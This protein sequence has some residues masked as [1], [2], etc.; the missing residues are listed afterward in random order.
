[1]SIKN[2]IFDLGG[3]LV[4]FNPKRR[5]NELFEEQYHN[6]INEN[7]YLSDEWKLMDSGD[8]TTE[9]AEEIMCS[10]LP[11]ELH[12]RVHEILFDHE[13]QMPPI[14]N[15]NLL[16]E[17]LFNSG[18]RLY[19]LSNCP[20]WFDEFRPFVPACKYFDGFVISADYH[21][22]KPDEAIYHTLFDK[23]Q[24]NA[25][26]CFFVDDSVANIETGKKLGMKGFCFKERNIEALIEELKNNG[27]AI[28]DN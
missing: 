5:M 21:Q 24:L 3:V 9:K 13:G 27:V 15:M 8:I 4:D 17:R 10:K 14:E 20:A 19:L 12:E 18:F 25:P 7:V 22:I 6:L 2:I 11:S 26:E 28:I 16:A 23:Y 1:M